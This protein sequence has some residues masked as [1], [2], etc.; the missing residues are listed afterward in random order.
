MPDLIGTSYFHRRVQVAFFQFSHRAFQLLDGVSHPGRDKHIYKD[1]YDNSYDRHNP[2]KLAV[3]H[4]SS[5]NIRSRG[6]ADDLPSRISHRLDRDLPFFSFKP[7][8]VAA[9][10]IPGCLLVILLNDSTVYQLLARVID[11]FPVAVDNI[12]VAGFS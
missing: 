9:F 7:F 4:I 12:Y 8:H 5:R 10:R 2:D 6:Y 3:L 11:Q 1:Q